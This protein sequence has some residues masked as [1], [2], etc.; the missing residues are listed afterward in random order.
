MF[1][2][3]FFF[4]YLV[5]VSDLISKQPHFNACHVI[6][7][8]ACLL[9]VLEVM[10][11]DGAHRV[12]VV[13]QMS[14]FGTDHELV[15]VIT[16]SAVVEFLHRNIASLGPI[17]T[18]EVCHAHFYKDVV[19][20]SED[21]LTSEAFKL[22]EM[23]HVSGLGVVDA[24]GVFVGDLSG[25]DLR[26][27]FET[28]NGLDFS[29]FLL[30]ISE[31]FKRFP[32][33]IPADSLT[34]TPRTLN[35][36]VIAKMVASKIHRVYILD[37]AKVPIGLLSLRDIIQRVVAPPHILREFIAKKLKPLLTAFHSTR[38]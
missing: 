28:K 35:K 30:K 16:Q 20:V 34:A 22:M 27:A 5:K 9:D 15:S 6:P 11:R 7:E 19:T 1:F 32:P 12:A 10:A 37:E 14:F 18:Q 25:K 29:V 33:A 4:F 23:T 24:R 21:S 31:F 38:K 17:G 13:T 36:D 8:N 3:F 26:R 2:F